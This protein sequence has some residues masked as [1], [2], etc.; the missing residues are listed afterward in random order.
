MPAISARRAGRGRWRWPRVAPRS[1]DRRG[2][3]RL[4]G[5]VRASTG[6]LSPAHP[7][8]PRR[9]DRSARPFPA[10]PSLPF[11]PLFLLTLILSP[12]PSSPPLQSPP[13]VVPAPSL[14]ELQILCIRSILPS[15]S[16]DG[17]PRS[18]QRRQ[19]FPY[20]SPSFIPTTFHAPPFL[21]GPALRALKT[22]HRV[23][24]PFLPS[25]PAHG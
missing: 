10:S 1:G 15:L 7:H 13:T 22:L 5:L 25:S 2:L 24:R 17:H 14:K 23:H 20:V 21:P 16:R 8:P 19:D 11:S 3:E 9:A 12:L 6:P 18:N 4:C